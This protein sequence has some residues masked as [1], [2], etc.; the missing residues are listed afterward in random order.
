VESKP[1]VIEMRRL[2]GTLNG[3]AKWMG[4]VVLLLSMRAVAQTVAANEAETVTANRL[5]VV[6]IPDRKLALLDNGKVVKVFPVAVGKDS[7]PSPEGTFTIKTR[8]ENPT[9]YHK[10]MVVAPGPQN[11]IGT[12][13]MGL[14]EKG[15]GIHGTNAPGSIGKA[16]SHGCIRMA[17]KD[18]E[19]LFSLVKVGDTVEIRGERDDEIARVFGV[20]AD[21]TLP[22]AVIAQSAVPASGLAGTR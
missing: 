17:K 11:P 7:S 4:T 16:A 22:A 1:G 20:Q 2:I 5:I 9:Y 13:W 15:Y 12:R 14:S 6:S 10:G 21:A 3:K 8:L 19:E 18:L